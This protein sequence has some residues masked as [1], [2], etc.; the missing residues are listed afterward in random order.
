MEGFAAFKTKWMVM[1]SK[2]GVVF[3]DGLRKHFEDE[4]FDI[5]LNIS[6]TLQ[7]SSRKNSEKDNKLLDVYDKLDN[8]H[9]QLNMKN[10]ELIKTMTKAHD[11]ENELYMVKSSARSIVKC[12]NVS[13]KASS[14]II[15]RTII[16]MVCRDQLHLIDL[17]VENS[18][19]KLYQRYSCSVRKS[20]WERLIERFFI[21]FV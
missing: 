9:V 18:I 12:L 4:M 16:E 21:F 20:I 14:N 8:A 17:S 6:S 3:D 2:D 1:I 7:D 10:E 15:A 11:F 19:H 5:F 13:L